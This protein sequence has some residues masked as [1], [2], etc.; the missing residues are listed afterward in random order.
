M[1]RLLAQGIVNA[2]VSFPPQSFGLAAR[3]RTD[4]FEENVRTDHTRRAYARAVRHFLQRSE[5]GRFDLPPIIAGSSCARHRD[6]TQRT[7]RS[8]V[9]LSR[10]EQ[11]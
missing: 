7:V 5:A 10:E 1:L 9:D 8:E 6:K 3:A 2:S 11:Q 4:L